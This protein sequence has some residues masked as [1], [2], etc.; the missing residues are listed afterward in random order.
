MFNGIDSSAARR[1]C[2]RSLFSV[3]LRKLDL[4]DS[5]VALNDLSVPPGNRLETLRGGRE[6][7]YSIRINDRYRVCSGW[8][9]AGASNVEIVDNYG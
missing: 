1:S 7:Q 9:D 8:S 5:A 6:G 4:L 3:A 2:R